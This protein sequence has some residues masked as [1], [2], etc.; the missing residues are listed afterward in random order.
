MRGTPDGYLLA[1]NADTGALLWARHV[2]KPG[3]RRDVHDG[4]RDLR[5]SRAHRT[6]RQREQPAGL[7]RRVPR[8]RRIAG[9]ALQHR[10]ETGRARLRHLEE[11]ER[12]SRRRR[13]GVDD[14][15]DR[16]R[17]RRHARRRDEPV[18]RSAGAPPAGRQPLHEL[19]RRPR[20]AHRQAALASSAR[21]QR[22]ARLGR[23]AC[24]ADVHHDDQRRDAPRD[25]HGRQGRH[26]ARDRPR[27]ASG[28]VRD[29]GDDA[30]ERRDPRVVLA[31]PRVPRRARRQPVERPGLQPGHE[32][33]LRARGGLVRDVLVVRAGPLHSGQELHGRQ[34]R[35]RS[36]VEIAGLAHRGRCVDRRREVEVPLAAADGGG[37]HDDGRQSR[38]RPAS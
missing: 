6:G 11:P 17:E 35:S 1:L 13:L 26:A 4:A 12:D 22:L 29:A 5:G 18:A 30:R 10:A 23:D 9:V 8:G 3:R 28:A 16:H 31:A 21:A 33:A 20:R 15:R 36:A 24:H 34:D 7:G 37:G 14:V 19:R 32:R 27:H 38:A 2:A 25:H